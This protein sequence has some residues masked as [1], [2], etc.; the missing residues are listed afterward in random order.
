MF[1]YLSINSLTLGPKNL[2]NRP[3]KQK[4]PPLPKIEATTKGI[5]ATLE[6]PAVIVNT[7]YGIGVKADV[8]TIKDEFF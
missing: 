5:K 8:N 3:T 2:N 6:T 7:L 4:R 1:K